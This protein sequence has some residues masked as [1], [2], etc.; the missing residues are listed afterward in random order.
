M[1]S[2]LHAAACLAATCATVVLAQDNETAPVS[3]FKTV[4][5]ILCPVQ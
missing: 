1:R 5:V 3:V 2:L 4:C